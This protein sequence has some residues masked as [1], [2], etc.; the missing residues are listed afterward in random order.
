MSGHLEVHVEALAAGGDG[1]A[2]HGGR[3]VFVRGGVPGDRVR[4]RVV[5]EHPRYLRA[6][7]QEILAASPRRVAPPC[8][9]A[10]RCGGCPWQHVAYAEQLRWKRQIVVDALERIGGLRSAPVAEPVGMAEPWAYRNKAA[11]P[12]AVAG[13]RLVLG[14]YARGTHRVVPVDTCA[15][16]HPLVNRVLGAVRGLAAEHRLTA[17]DEATGTGLLRHLVVRVSFTTD[18]ALACL[19]INAPAFPGERDL[20]AALLAAVPGLAGVVKNVNLSRGNAIFGPHTEAL[21]GRDH[22]MEVVGGMSFRVSATSFFQVNTLQAERLY[23]LALAAAAPEPVAAAV[24]VYCGTGTLACLL[25]R[26]ARRVWGIESHPAAVA[27]ARANARTNGLTGIE[28][29]LGP[30]EGEVPRLAREGVRA[31]AVILDP[32]RKGCDAAVLDAVPALAPRRLVYVSCNPATLAR[33]LAR[34]VATGRYRL[35]SVQPVD[36]FPHTPHVE[37]VAALEAAS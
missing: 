22:V 19:V 14:F 33:D 17:Y 16:Q 27:D 8:P 26:R 30:A 34:L 37:V 18:E 32:P 3:V 4:V 23:D 7:V 20:A 13:E 31:D 11:L 10:G 28:F 2:R 36:L 5:E 12:F 9:V 21:A 29:R 15:V 1:V 35:V 6:E 25:A 24:D